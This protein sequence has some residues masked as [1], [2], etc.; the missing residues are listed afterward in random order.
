MFFFGPD[1]PAGGGCDAAAAADP[2]WG[3]VRGMAPG[4]S[5]ADTWMLPGAA[6]PAGGRPGPPPSAATCLAVSR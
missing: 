4:R 1:G 3:T 2:G 5:G 6:I